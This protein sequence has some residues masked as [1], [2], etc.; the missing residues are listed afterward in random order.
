MLETLIGA[1][2]EAVFGY[3]LE[4]AGLAEKTRTLLKRNPQR[5]AFQVALTR[6]YATFSE[7]HPQW[8]GALFDQHFL[9]H[10]AAPL[11]ARCLL[12]SD[13]PTGAELAAT[14]A[15]HLALSEET[16]TRRLPEA[17]QVAAD[18]LATLDREL[19]DRS[20]LQPLFDSRALDTTA[21][22]TTQT[23]QSTAEIA[24]EMRL[25]REELN[26]LLQQ[27]MAERPADQQNIRNDAPNQGAQGIFNGPVTFNYGL[28]PA[29]TPPPPTTPPV[30]TGTNPFIAGN[31]V[32]PEQFYG[33]KQQWNTIKE[34]IMRCISGNS[35]QCISIV[36]FSRSG[37]QSMLNYIN[38]RIE[39]ELYIYK[40][41]LVRINLKEQRFHTPEGITEGLRREI[42]KVTGKTPWPP[43]KNT[44]SWTAWEIHDGLQE[45][46]YSGY[47]LFVLIDGFHNIKRLLREDSTGWDHDLSEKV[48]N[49]HLILINTTMFSIDKIYDKIDMNSPFGAVCTTELGALLTEEW[50]ALV[51]DGFVST[52]KRVSEAEMTF[53]DD[54]AG[55]LPYYTQLAAE[56][57]WQYGD[58]SYTH[59]EFTLQT[60]DTFAALWRSLTIEEQ[61]TLIQATSSRGLIQ[62]IT[63]LN[64]RKHGLI[65][66]DGS[67]FS[68]V[69][70]KFVQSKADTR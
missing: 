37:K 62:S 50:H 22:A 61:D 29:T 44:D 15:E 30:R 12:R 4:Q 20:E 16:R 65:K 51:H 46:R 59:N 39:E 17:T 60:E 70:A 11:L 32:P 1:V 52:G 21:A 49:G 14:W 64:L 5:L 28:P 34:C 41:I 58:Y 53:L 26:R 67:L 2:T 40:P 66:L 63:T 47:H 7:Q 23:A 43:A 31:A 18:F 13:P 55:G 36:G 19:R 8:T 57:L 54:L 6:T 45:L 69:F 10:A 35:L 33:R 42:K 9:A 24:E 27:I 3:L 25:L 38:K 56:L 48:K 68:S